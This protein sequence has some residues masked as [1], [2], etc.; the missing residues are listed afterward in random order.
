MAPRRLLH[1]LPALTL[2]LA[3]DLAA[4]EPDLRYGEEINELC[5][6]CHG[7]YG[8]GGKDGEY[9]RLA[10]Q[11]AD[12]LARQL[13]L[14]RNRELPN[15]AML[16]HMD[17]RQFPNEDIED[18]SAYLAGIQL[19]TEMPP[20]DESAE[21]DAL[22]RLRM[23]KQVL[24]IPRAEGDVKAG[25]RIYN[26][27]CRSCHG[28]SGRGRDDKAVPMLAGQYTDYLSRQVEKYRE[29]IRIHDPDDPDDRLLTQFTDDELRDVF[30][31]LSITDDR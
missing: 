24:N 11:P 8:E 16:E 20:L 5:A 1:L 23:T 7:E 15:M 22:E 25:E 4:R 17:E 28:E 19:M 27:E 18:V 13:Y 12:Y 2:L 10:G 30:A 26:R 29:G 3:A 9:P 6:G 31:Y 21:F 14:F